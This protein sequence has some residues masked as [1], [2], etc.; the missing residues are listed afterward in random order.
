MLSLV[1][2]VVLGIV[3]LVWS[4]ERFVYGASA[5]AANLGIAPL[6][7]GLVVVGTGTSAPEVLVSTLAALDGTPGLAVGNA[8]GSNIANVGLVIG[9]T[10]LVVPIAV[11][12]QT[13][14]REFP[15]MFAVIGLAWLLLSDG[16]L[17][18]FEG[19]CLLAGFLVLIALMVVLARRARGGDPL[20]QEFAAE[21]SRRVG[22]GVAIAWTLAGLAALLVSSR[23]LV[24][25]ASGIA[26]A[27]G[28][29]DLVI[30]LTIVAVG[31]S[32]PELG[33][34]VA[35]VAKG[36]PDIAVGILLG[37]NMFNL[38][39]V[40]AMPGLIAP[41][42]LPR[43]TLVRDLP[44]MTAFSVA[45]LLTAYGFRGPGK[46]NRWEAALLVIAFAGYQ[47]VLYHSEMV[48]S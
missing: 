44:V 12:S 32:L 21:V 29:S 36:E 18:R 48:G 4:S 41:A 10:A 38:L 11:D 2:A 13:L 34:S 43:L 22:T 47:L 27:L 16:R 15:L 8:I 28:V 17:G 25:G 45:L 6:V 14:R 42:E 5:T 3:G 24:W 19:A 7:I 31:T 33:A 37:S 46:V 23:A 35:S 26:H 9:V 20:G 30:G 40:L 1:I 39:A